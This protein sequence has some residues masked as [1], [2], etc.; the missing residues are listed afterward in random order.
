MNIPEGLGRRRFWQAQPV[1]VLAIRFLEQTSFFL[2]FLFLTQ[3]YLAE[4]RGLGVAFAGFVIT[5]FG[6]TK[7]VS[8]APAGWLGDRFGY[9]RS[10]MLGM[11]VSLLAAALL[12]NLN[13]AWVLLAATALFSLGKAPLGPALD[14]TIANL[15]EEDARGKAVAAVNA[16]GLAAYGIAGVA[17]LMMLDVAPSRAFFLTTIALNAAA[18]AVAALWLKETASCAR[19]PRGE[20]RRWPPLAVLLN[21]QILTW[22]G[23]VLL[24]G[25]GTGL[26]APVAQ[27]YVRDVLK[28]EM[29]ELAPYLAL[30]AA[31][32]ALSILPAGHLADRL[33]RA[34]PLALG[35]GMG[36]IGMLGVSFTASV[37]PLMGLAALI[38]LSY[39]LASPAVA[40][41]LMD[42]TQEGTRGFVLG[43]LSTA[44]GVGGA[45]GPAVGGGIYASLTP[46]D[47][48][49]TAGFVLMGAMLLTMA[50]SG[51]R[52]LS[53]APAPVLVDD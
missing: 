23:I 8:Q 17:G 40:A 39:T 4:D 22:A 36:A 30:P 13:Q 37:W 10:L 45:L 1:P 20:R 41:A 47:V 19:R 32:A 33:G 34:R 14:A 28:M 43:A 38:M 31:L 52:Q 16:S 51:W 25:F 11:S 26:V 53:Y 12:M 18:L 29:R 9:K 44:G 35:L 46:Q 50:Y 48:F 3:R 27:P 7:L 5:V 2:L 21:P 24:V 6:I 15:Y 42:V 49:F